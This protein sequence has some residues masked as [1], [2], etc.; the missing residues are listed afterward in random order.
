MSFV[1]LIL[2]LP[3]RLPLKVGL[4]AAAAQDTNMSAS[5]LKQEYG[6]EWLTA[7]AMNYESLINS[8]SNYSTNST[9]RLKKELPRDKITN[10]VMLLFEDEKFSDIDNFEASDIMLRLQE[11][12]E[13]T[14]CNDYLRSVPSV[15][16][17]YF[18]YDTLL[19]EPDEGDEV[20]VKLKEKRK[21][22]SKSHRYRLYDEECD[23]NNETMFW[24][25][26]FKVAAND[27]MK[28]ASNGIPGQTNLGPEDYSYL[29]LSMAKI[30][31][32]WN[33]VWINFESKA[34]CNQRL[35]LE[36][37]S[38][39]CRCR[40]SSVGRYA[41]YGSEKDP[42][43]M[44]TY[45][46]RHYYTNY[47]LVLDEELR[48]W[49][50]GHQYKYGDKC[51]L[52]VVRDGKEDDGKN[53]PNSCDFFLPMI[54]MCR[55]ECVEN[56]TCISADEVVKN[57]VERKSQGKILPG[58][59][60]VD[61]K[62]STIHTMSLI[63]LPTPD[64]DLTIIESESDIN[65]APIVPTL[66]K[67][68]GQIGAV[69]S[70]PISGYAMLRF[71]RKYC[72]LIS[73]IILS[74][75]WFLLGLG[76]VVLK[77]SNNGAV[78]MM[79]AG[80]FLTG[81]AGAAS[82]SVAPVYVKEICCDELRTKMGGMVPLL[83]IIGN[84]Y[85]C[86]VRNRLV[87]ILVLS[88]LLLSNLSNTAINTYYLAA[89]VSEAIR[90]LINKGRNEDG[91]KSMLWYYQ[92]FEKEEGERAFK[93]QFSGI[94]LITI[95]TTDIFKAS[96]GLV[97][98]KVGTILVGLSLVI[99]VV[100]TVI[101]LDGCGRKRLLQIG[102]LVKGICLFALGTYFFLNEKKSSAA[103]KLRWV[104][105]LA[106][107]IYVSAYS[108]GMGSV[109]WTLTTEINHP[110]CREISNTLTFTTYWLVAFVV[111]A[112]L[113]ALRNWI[114]YH[115]CFFFYGTS[116]LI[117]FIFV[118]FCIYETKGKT[119]EEIMA[120]YRGSTLYLDEDDD[121]KAK[122]VK[123]LGSLEPTKHASNSS[124][125]HTGRDSIVSTDTG[126]SEMNVLYQ[127]ETGDA[128]KLENL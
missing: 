77:S 90:C 16:N 17:K 22:E 34:V 127:D 61:K 81:F 109:P 114:G 44:K 9:G 20:F 5:T 85:G 117:S 26:M 110:A 51:M 32:E 67:C 58:R 48:N 99:F 41:M 53:Y 71:G 126:G 76:K 10:Q 104:P 1:L 95:Y 4:L 108:L 54:G 18:K 42:M 65:L 121:A 92:G 89:G 14:E 59:I 80:R 106:V 52:G 96:G 91:E 82:L 38:G 49:E 3:L 7:L 8:F 105:V 119:T 66:W 2:P 72:M 124:G 31:E 28:Y 69:I 116:C 62:H 86:P 40:Q 37:F 118:T 23:E 21:A 50:V 125:A 45:I 70:G 36:C 46:S 56:A 39:K 93:Q 60:R 115:S 33:S 15:G 63:Q 123:S 24:Q 11:K 101:F 75:S 122:Y 55:A 68:R 128:G 94:S 19:L 47:T 107:V 27:T 102:T 35:L 43:S 30:M 79:Y 103:E 120:H 111:T 12:Y 25:E 6:K 29:Q 83:M 64:D 87:Y 74:L 88:Q 100:V 57:S 97:S 113:P 78:A 84:L 73:A 112:S 98:P 13:Y